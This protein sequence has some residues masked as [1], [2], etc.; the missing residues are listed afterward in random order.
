MDNILLDSE[1]HIKIAEY[2]LYFEYVLLSN[3]HDFSFG[4]CKEGIINDRKTS[5]FCG[6]P[7]KYFHKIILFNKSYL[8]FLIS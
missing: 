3:C 1:G 7:G 8:V 2:E 4:M 6:T 5:T